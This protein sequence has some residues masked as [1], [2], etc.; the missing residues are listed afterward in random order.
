MGTWNF[1]AGR[2]WALAVFCLSG[3][4]YSLSTVLLHEP[5]SF[6]TWL[7]VMV[8]FGVV[9]LLTAAFLAG[10]DRRPFGWKRM[11]WSITAGILAA[12]GY[13]YFSDDVS[14]G[15]YITGGLVFGTILC[16]YGPALPPHRTLR[17]LDHGA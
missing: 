3:L 8:G 17:S 2:H 1:K 6:F 4:I 5:F 12:V 7:F 13:A 15:Y 11:L 14:K 10:R 16:Y 9:C